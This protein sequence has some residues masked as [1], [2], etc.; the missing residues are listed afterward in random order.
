VGVKAIFKFQDDWLK[1]KV[2]CEMSGVDH[3]LDLEDKEKSF[4]HT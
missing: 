3:D 1:S 4:P 2:L